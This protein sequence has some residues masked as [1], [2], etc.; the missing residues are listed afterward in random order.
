MVYSI[1]TVIN[2]RKQNWGF[3]WAKIIDRLV[4][5][6]ISI[7]K[8]T[9]TPDR[10][11][12]FQIKKHKEVRYQ[13]LLT[14]MQ[15]AKRWRPYLESRRE[16]NHFFCLDIPQAIHTGN[17]ITNW[18]NAASFL[19]LGRGVRAQDTFLQNRRYFSGAWNNLSQDNNVFLCHP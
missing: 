8:V 6:N 3:Q 5:N 11:K 16:L 13:Y 17:T 9:H 15:M 18:E 4:L 19:Q 1:R 14:Q 2:I 10:K 12:G 7:P